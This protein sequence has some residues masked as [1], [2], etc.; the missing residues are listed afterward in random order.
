MDGQH[1]RNANRK[2]RVLGL[3]PE[4]LHTQ[5]RAQAAADGSSA[6]KGAFRDPPC[7][8]YGLALVRK[9]KHK[10]CGIDYSEV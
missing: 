2:S 10:G 3:V 6:Q 5:Q 8:F 9:H 1:H 7:L 4:Q